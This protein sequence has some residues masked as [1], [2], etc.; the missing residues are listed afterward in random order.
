M[1]MCVYVCLCGY[2]RVCTCMCTW[3]YMYV[4]VSVWVYMCVRV[5]AYVYV[6]VFACCVY[7][8]VQCHVPVLRVGCLFVIDHFNSKQVLDSC[9][10]QKV[11]RFCTSYQSLRISSL[12]TNHHHLNFVFPMFIIAP[13][14]KKKKCRKVHFWLIDWWYIFLFQ[15]LNGWMSGTGVVFFFFWTVCIG[16]FL[17]K[18]SKVHRWFRMTIIQICES[19]YTTSLIIQCWTLNLESPKHFTSLIH[20]FSFFSQLEQP[21]D[22]SFHAS[23]FLI[24]KRDVLLLFLYIFFPPA[25]VPHFYRVRLNKRC[26]RQRSVTQS[27]FRNAHDEEQLDAGWA[28]EVT[29]TGIELSQKKLWIWLLATAS[30]SAFI[31]IYH[32]YVLY[33]IFFIYYYCYI[34]NKHCHY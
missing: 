4:Y 14:L 31:F 27:N 30:S 29:V 2:V 8:C 28:K 12:D 33:T 17:L 23:F 15:I 1:C 11:A 3:V 20:K 26:D 13:L 34:L 19:L 21:A 18:S 16:N 5:Y 22:Q 7:M 25:F 32:Y 6:C 24:L 10:G 9:F